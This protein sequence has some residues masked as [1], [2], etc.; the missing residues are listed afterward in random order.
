[1]SEI[2]KE[3]KN[4]AELRS[5]ASD[6][7]DDKRRK[8]DVRIYCNNGTLPHFRQSYMTAKIRCCEEVSNT[9]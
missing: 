3:W 1:M 6:S 5:D 2:G 9:S 7:D 4:V 8:S